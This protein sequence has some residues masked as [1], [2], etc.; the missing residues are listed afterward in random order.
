[1]YDAE[2]HDRARRVA[3]L[4]GVGTQLEPEPEPEPEP[5]LKP[6][7]ALSHRVSQLE[8]RLGELRAQ[9]SEATLEHRH[10]TS[11]PQPDSTPELQPK[12]EPEPS[13]ELVKHSRLTE[14]EMAALPWWERVDA[15]GDDD[16][17]EARSSEQGAVAVD[18]A[19]IV[20]AM[21]SNLEICQLASLEVRTARRLERRALKQAKEGPVPEPEVE[22]EPEPEPA[23]SWQPS[24]VWELEPQPE[25]EN[26]KAAKKAMAAQ[27]K[28]EAK[29][30]K[31]A[32]KAAALAA[33]ARKKKGG[34]EPEPDADT[35]QQP[36]PE[37][38][39]V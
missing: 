28:L 25:P 15:M 23:P 21:P 13:V 20:A 17:D 32:K 1:M 6:T 37:A 36:E 11:K 39:A 22:S 33:K 2:L 19:A 12:P 34:A 10:T 38:E 29:E 35:V 18:V 16:G 4:V 24:S 9:L 30:A 26:S 27:K 14:A 3:I 5:E 7:S 31:E 8:V